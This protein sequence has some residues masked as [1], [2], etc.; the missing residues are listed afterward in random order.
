MGKYSKK[1]KDTGV[2]EGLRQLAGGLVELLD[3]IPHA[4]G[5][6]MKGTGRAAKRTS[7][8]G[9]Y[10]L[11]EAGKGGGYLLHGTG[12]LVRGSGGLVRRLSNAAAKKAEGDYVKIRRNDFEGL[13]DLEPAQQEKALRH[14]LTDTNSGMVSI[15]R[16]ALRDALT[17]LRKYEGPARG[18][19][20]VLRDRIGLEQAAAVL[21]LGSSIFFF[22]KASITGYAVTAATGTSL[23]GYYSLIGFTF[24][25]VAVLVL[26]FNEKRRRRL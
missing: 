8:G 25:G 18:K 17:H 5:S 4:V 14:Y 16:T 22:D 13:L 3:A 10:G 20:R 23:G 1:K 12:D 26:V 6:L 7:E 24:L 21:F 15:K 2:S 9:Q 11:E 19:K